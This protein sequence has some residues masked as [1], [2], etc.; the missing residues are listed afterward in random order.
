[1]ET[2]YPTR[3]SDFHSG[4]IV[5]IT[6][7]IGMAKRVNEII[8][9]EILRLCHINIPVEI[10]YYPLSFRWNRSGKAKTRADEYRMDVPKD[11]EDQDEHEDREL[12]D[13]SVL[14]H[15]CIVPRMRGDVI[16]DCRAVSSRRDK[17]PRAS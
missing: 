6:Y 7:P 8:G 16:A 14:S 11:V 13:G 2:I 3:R 9:G 17:T 1:M 10:P 4:D 12:L 5:R 15:G